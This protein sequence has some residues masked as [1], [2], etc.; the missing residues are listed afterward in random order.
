[1]RFWVTEYDIDGFRCDYAAGVPVD[2]WADARAQLEQVKPVFFLEEDLAG[3]N[4]KLLEEAFDC[5]YSAKFLETLIHVGHNNKTADKLRMYRLSMPEGDFPMYYLDNHD[6]NSY[7]RTIA[8]AFTEEIRPAMWTVIFTMPGIPMLYSGDE[9]TY[10]HKIAFMEK[11]PIDWNA[12]T[13][14]AA[15][16][17]T[18]LARIKKENPALYAGAPG[19]PIEDIKLEG[20][21][22]VAFRRSTGD[23]SIV[24]LFNLSR[25]GYENAD[26]TDVALD[27]GTVLLSGKEGSWSTEGSVPDTT[28]TFSP[29]E[30]MIIREGDAQ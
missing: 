4:G 28:Y 5:N 24:C 30:F 21:N 25:D 3:Q 20:K 8:E 9:I 19:G 29:W 22:L 27:G 7:D 1:M 11:D 15:P 23:N 2:F 6:V 26:L 17:I 14:D 10:D 18:E 13:W 12:V 16:L